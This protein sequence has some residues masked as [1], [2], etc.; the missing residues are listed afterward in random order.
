MSKIVSN[1]A[2]QLQD[3]D[4]FQPIITPVL[5]LTRVQEDAKAISTMIPANASYLQAAAIARSPQPGIE[6]VGGTVPPGVG[7]VRF[8]QNIYAPEQLS[9]ADIYRQTRNQIA[10]AKEELH[11]P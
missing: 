1:M 7:D 9:T 10:L 8:E 5:D 2:D 6:Q 3:V 4:E 11:I